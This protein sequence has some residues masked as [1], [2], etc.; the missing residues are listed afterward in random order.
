MITLDE[1]DQEMD[2]DEC[3]ADPFAGWWPG[4][5][6]MGPRE[7]RRRYNQAKLDAYTQNHLQETSARIA[8]VVDAKMLVSP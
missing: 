6:D 8:K 7:F 3:E 4:L 2:D 1:Q 5:T